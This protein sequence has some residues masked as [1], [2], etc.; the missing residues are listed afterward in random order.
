MSA[1][2]KCPSCG[3]LMGDPTEYV[4][5]ASLDEFREDGFLSWPLPENRCDGLQFA[6]KC[7]LTLDVPLMAPVP[8][9]THP[10]GTP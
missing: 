10:K 3:S 7:G 6:C 8:E 9:S 1:K 4:N 5:A 2:V